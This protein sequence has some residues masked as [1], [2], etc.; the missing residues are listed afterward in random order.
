MYHVLIGGT[1][2]K[3]P[4]PLPI[5]I[6][7]KGLRDSLTAFYP[8]GWWAWL[9]ILF[10]PWSAVI[11]VRYIPL[12]MNNLKWWRKQV[13]CQLWVSPR[14]FAYCLFIIQFHLECFC[15]KIDTM[16][17]INPKTYDYSQN[18][19]FTLVIYYFFTNR[20]MSKETIG[21]IMVPI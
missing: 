2:F 20:E 8:M 7:H 3:S 1:L 17:F 14:L 5:I 15:L 6:K 13:N 9:V 19:Q 11:L 18:H 4:P 21:T 10:F 16:F 12:S